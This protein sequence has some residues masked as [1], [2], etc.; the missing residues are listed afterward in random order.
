[1]IGRSKGQHADVESANG[2]NA[3]QLEQKGE[4]GIVLKV[5]LASSTAFNRDI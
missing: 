3:S 2:P 5:Y 1:M 4:K